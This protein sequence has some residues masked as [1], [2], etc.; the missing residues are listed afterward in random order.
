MQHAPVQVLKKSDFEPYVPLILPMVLTLFFAMAFV[1]FAYFV[2][3][4]C[5]FSFRTSKMCMYSVVIMV[6]AF[7][8]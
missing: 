4:I 7:F 6:F 3:V 8:D 1:E 2:L 5:P